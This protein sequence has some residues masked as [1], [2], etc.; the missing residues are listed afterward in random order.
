MP[1]AP[2]THPRCQ[3]RL[4][5]DVRLGS[6][7]EYACL[8]TKDISCGGLFIETDDPGDLFSAIEVRLHL[9]EGVG[10]IALSAQVVRVI[11]TDCKPEGAKAG[12]GVRFTDVSEEHQRQLAAWFERHGGRPALPVAVSAGVGRGSLPSISESELPALP[13]GVQAALENKLASLDGEPL[14]VLGVPPTA[15]QAALR[16]SYL[17][18]AKKYHPQRWAH[19][20]DQEI[21]QLVARIF[22]ALERAYE[23]AKAGLEGARSSP[24]EVGGHAPVDPIHRSTHADLSAFAAEIREPRS[25]PPSAAVQAQ[26]SEALKHLA[27][28]RHD[29][30]RASLQRVLD[31]APDNKQAQT[32]IRVAEA[33]QLQQ[34]GDKADAIVVYRQILDEIDPAHGEALKEVRAGA[35]RLSSLFKKIVGR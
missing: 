8:Y 7:A 17:A 19:Y 34:L 4:A 22:D 20:E 12:M 11:P 27:L 31:Q 9:P 2:R 15:D 24:R 1:E 33:R 6:W 29:L 16:R 18:Q 14:E 26:I 3:S 10:T 30:A 13:A 21:S 23:A 32:W 5:V 35:G 28:K 25:E